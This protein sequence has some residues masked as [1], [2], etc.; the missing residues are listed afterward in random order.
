M[1]SVANSASAKLTSTESGSQDASAPKTPIST[2]SIVSKIPGRSTIPAEAASNPHH[3]I[4]RGTVVGFKNPYPSWSGAPGFGTML[5]RVV[6]PSITGDLKMP[7]TSPPTVPVV[8]PQWLPD[9][10]SSDKLRATWLG[11]ACYYVEFPSGLRV[12]FDPVFEDRC[13]PFTFMGPKRY[14]PKPCDIKDIPIVDAVV[15]SHS[16]YDHLSHSS[17]LEVQK[18]HPEAQFFVGLGLETW[19]RKTG[20]HHVTELDWWEDADLSVT[21]RDG[22]HT[23][24][25]TARISCLP[26]QHTSARTLW[27]KDTTLWCSW[28]VRADEKSVW[29]GGDTGYRAVPAIPAGIDDYGADYEALPRCPQFKQ[30]GELRGPF[31]LGLIPIGAYYPRVA[32]SAMHANPYDSVEIFCDTKCTRAMGI[33]WGTWALTMEEVLEP[34][35]MLKEALRKKNI[36]EVGVF[37]ICDIGES[38]EF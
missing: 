8:K 22:D 11:H 18:Y 21:V 5:R 29:F 25:M 14:T 36:P 30:I 7:D 20:I 28:A 4:K 35:K 16:H 6:W 33:H 34:P 26:C 12:L 15:I 9:R 10:D 32:F 1:A 3:E 13:S 17:I 37:D 19:F 31:D 27:D 23:R 38:R 24:E 2:T